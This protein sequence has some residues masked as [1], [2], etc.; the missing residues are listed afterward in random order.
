MVSLLKAFPP[1]KESGKPQPEATQTQ[2][3]DK[4]L[5][6]AGRELDAIASSEGHRDMKASPVDRF[7]VLLADWDVCET[8]RLIAVKNFL[9]MHELPG[10]K[11]AIQSEYLDA[12]ARVAWHEKEMLSILPDIDE[13]D[14]RALMAGQRYLFRP[15]DGLAYYLVVKPELR[16]RLKAA[17]E[18]R[19]EKQ[20]L[21]SK[22]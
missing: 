7:L 8:R 6:D 20:L 13:R 5:A 15:T 21:S 4:E 22:K 10:D 12:K 1:T 17:I 9:M 3:S 2:Y 11:K 19:E 16:D 14:L 18:K